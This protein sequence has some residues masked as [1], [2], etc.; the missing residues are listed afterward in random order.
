MTWSFIFLAAIEVVTCQYSNMTIEC[1]FDSKI[2]IDSAVF[3]HYENHHCEGN[4][5][6]DNCHSPGDFDLVDGLCSGNQACEMFVDWRTFGPDPCPGTR[7]YLQLQY[8][9]VNLSKYTFLSDTGLMTK[10]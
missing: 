10:R 1:P 3:G 4:V 7:K 6:H 9:C 5:V 2:R 8:T